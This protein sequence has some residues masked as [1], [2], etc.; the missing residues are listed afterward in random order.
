M[1]SVIRQSI[2]V[3]QKVHT[4]NLKSTKDMFGDF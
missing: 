3:A 1:D 2:V 4:M